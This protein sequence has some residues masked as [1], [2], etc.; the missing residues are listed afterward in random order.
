[1]HLPVTRHIAVV[2]GGD[3]FIIML[4]CCI[5]GIDRRWRRAILPALG[6]RRHRHLQ[7]GKE[8]WLPRLLVGTWAAWPR[9]LYVEIIAYTNNN[10]NITPNQLARVYVYLC[11]TRRRP[12]LYGTLK[13]ETTCPHPF[14]LYLRF[15]MDKIVLCFYMIWCSVDSPLWK[16]TPS[17][18]TASLLGIMCKTGEQGSSFPLPRSYSFLIYFL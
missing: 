3:Y 4:L 10:I 17:V 8:G 6:R 14:T 1:M 12:V 18:H 13:T 5:D 7:G 9:F 16:T 2:Q 11:S 15:W